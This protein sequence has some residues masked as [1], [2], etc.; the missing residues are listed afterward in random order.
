VKPTPVHPD[1]AARAIPG[2]IKSLTNRIVTIAAGRSGIGAICG[3]KV[4]AAPQ[5][6]APA[7]D[8]E[9]LLDKWPGA[10]SGGHHAADREPDHGETGSVRH[11]PRQQKGQRKA[12]PAGGQG[13]DW[14]EPKVFSRVVRINHALRLS[15]STKGYNW[16]DIIYLCGCTP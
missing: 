10:K 14:P 11:G 9:Y 6:P 16:Q 12:P 2:A 3:F 1:R 4:I 15:N 5:R 8:R 13:A 7:G